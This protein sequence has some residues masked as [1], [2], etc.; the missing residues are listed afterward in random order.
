VGLVG[1]LP[2]LPNSSREILWKTLAGLGIAITVYAFWQ[3][4]ASYH[5]LLRQVA[6]NT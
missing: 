6:G 4:Y 3:D 2:G 5:A 1:G